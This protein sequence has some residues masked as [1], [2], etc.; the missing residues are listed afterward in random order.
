L[1]RHFLKLLGK[2]YEKPFHE[3]SDEAKEKLIAHHWPGNLRE[4][5]HSVNMLSSLDYRNGASVF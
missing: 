4:L 2:R 5:E 1:A 3:F